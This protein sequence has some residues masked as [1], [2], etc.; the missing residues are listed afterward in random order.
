MEKRNDTRNFSWLLMFRNK[1]IKGIVPTTDDKNNFLK[2]VI[3]V[4]RSPTPRSIT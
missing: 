1:N 4:K 2:F 3:L